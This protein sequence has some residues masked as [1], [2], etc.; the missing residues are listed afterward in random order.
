MLKQSRISK[1]AQDALAS[2]FEP[3]SSRKSAR[4]GFGLS[5]AEKKAVKL[6]AMAQASAELKRLGFTVEDCSAKRSFDLVAKRAGQELV[7]EVK[8]TTGRGEAVILTHREVIAQRD[9]YPLNCLIVVHSITLDRSGE[10]PNASGGTLAILQ[11]WLIEDAQLK[12][13]SYQYTCPSGS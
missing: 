1:E 3:R 10:I 4:Q 5:T 7:V 6:H 11:P 8:G 9:A 12:P 2:F 13:T